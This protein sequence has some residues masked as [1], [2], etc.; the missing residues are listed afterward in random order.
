MVELMVGPAEVVPNEMEETGV[1]EEPIVTAPD[2]L[3]VPAEIVVAPFKVKL[4]EPLIVPPDILIVPVDV[5][6]I[7]EFMVRAPPVI[8]R[9]AMVMVEASV[10]LLVTVPMV[11]LSVIDP[12]LPG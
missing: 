3:T 4:P 10:G 1:A 6:V 12:A 8:V 5:N 2:K 9:F 11:T 7:P